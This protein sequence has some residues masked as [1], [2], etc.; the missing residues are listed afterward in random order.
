MSAIDDCLAMHKEVWHSVARYTVYCITKPEG[1][2]P[3]GVRS[4]VQSGMSFADAT[5]LAEQEGAPFVEQSS[6]TKPLFGLTL[7]NPDEAKAAVRN[8]DIWSR[9][10]SNPAVVAAA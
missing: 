5:V 3:S 7:E 6:W 8:A 2:P 4:V 1:S 9:L 10:T